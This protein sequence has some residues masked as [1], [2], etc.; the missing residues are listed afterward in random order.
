MNLDFENIDQL[1]EDSLEGMEI[2][3]SPKVKLMVQQNMFWQ[4]AVKSLFFKAG[5]S[6]VTL[7]SVAGAFWYA[8]STGP[9]T[10]DI[11]IENEMQT[12]LAV[13]TVHSKN[14]VSNEI[15]FNDVN[16]N[17]NQEQNTTETK[18]ILKQTINPIEPKTNQSIELE[19]E[20]ETQTINKRPTQKTKIK[21]NTEAT[22]SS[23]ER[24]GIPENQGSKR[25]KLMPED[26]KIEK[27][28]NIK[29]TS[30]EQL[31]KREQVNTVTDTQEQK[32]LASNTGVHSSPKRTIDVLGTQAPIA[33]VLSSSDGSSKDN[34]VTIEDQSSPQINKINKMPARSVQEIILAEFPSSEILDDAYRWFEDTVGVNV[35]GEP[36]VLSS[37]RWSVGLYGQGHYTMSRFKSSE[38]EQKDLSILNKAAIK[39][40]LSYGFGAEVSYQFKQ[41]SVGLGLQYERYEQTFTATENNLNIE[42]INTWNRFDVDH[43]QVDSTAYLNI[44]SLWAGDTI[45][46]YVKDS[47]NLLTKDSTLISRTDS[48]WTESTLNLR[49]VYQYFEIPIFFDYTFN[50]SEKWQPFARVGLVTGVYI[51][52]KAN[53]IISDGQRLVLDDLPFAKFN[54]W[55]HLGLGIK[56]NMNKK[57]TAYSQVHYK[58]N[59][60]AILKDDSSLEQSIDPIS[61]RL[62]I[63]YHF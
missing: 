46:V 13:E 30:T 32:S 48:N 41:L 33:N 45:L 19:R 6:I 3:P 51:K 36:I 44:D 61:L 16:I 29:E 28:T 1:F 5:L 40:A 50:R 7:M 56:Y 2:T 9:K 20:S 25:S 35:K 4:N 26:I 11:A 39:P 58:F 49:N 8:S 37:D 24:L 62:G 14:I 59:I 10:T 31:T 54:F 47:V 18:D 17:S 63:Q 21:T 53:I 43:W 12:G 55:G 34:P 15:A 27:Q 57:W 38:S 42:Q 23:E 22:V 60:N 52:S